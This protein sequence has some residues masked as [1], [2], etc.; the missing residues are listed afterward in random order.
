MRVKVSVIVPVYNAA[1]YIADCM[2]ALLT[3]TL[4]DCEFIFIDDGSTDGSGDL[5]EAYRTQDRRLKV[6]HQSNQG[7]SLARNHGLALASGEYIGFMDADD[8]VDPDYFETMYLA[9]I[10]D[11]CDVVVSNYER[12]MEGH[13]S[14]IRFPFTM[15]ARLSQE[16][17]G[18]VVLPYFMQEDSLN[19]VWN[20]L[21]RTE[22]IV[23]G[24]VEFPARVALGEDQWFNLLFFSTAVSMKYIDY[25]GYHYKEVDSSA[26]R[27][28]A[29]KDYFARALEVYR[30]ELPAPFTRTLDPA[31]LHKW[32]AIKL[33]SN[34]MSY[35]YLYYKAPSQLSFRQR[36]QYIKSMI[37][38]PEVQEALPIYKQHR[39]GSS[40]AYEKLLLALIHQRSALGLYC[41]TTYSR[42]KNAI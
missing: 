36:Y 16:D 24:R 2:Q 25:T 26:T 33:I 42:L 15:G 29:S 4:L 35:V 17:I 7:V 5:L 37:Q 3:Q 27:S 8:L 38:H 21:Y 20:K 10:Q 18:Q 11:D 30:A 14:I 19:S 31:L 22:A 28:F 39:Q 1:P 34:V 32:R 12:E 13:R 41:A 6:V 9:A 23:A 40:D